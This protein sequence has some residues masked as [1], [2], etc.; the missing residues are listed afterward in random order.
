MARL[1]PFPGRTRKVRR[2]HK[3]V[4]CSRCRWTWVPY[5]RKR[6]ARCAHA[7]CRSPY[8][9]TPRRERP[10]EGQQP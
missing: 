9:D 5:S 6:P 3:P 4:T 7:S 1:T 8:W 10:A 2:K